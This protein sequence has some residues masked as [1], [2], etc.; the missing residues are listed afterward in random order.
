[1]RRIGAGM[2]KCTSAIAVIVRSARSCIHVAE[3]L[4]A[5]DHAGRV[6]VEVGHRGVDVGA[7]EDPL[8]GGVHQ[9]GQPLQLGPAPGVG[10]VEVDLGAEE[11]AAGQRV[12]LPPDALACSAPCGSSSS[13][14]NSPNAAVAALAA[15]ARARSSVAVAALAGGRRGRGRSRPPRRTDRSSGAP[16]RPPRRTAAP[17]RR[18]PCA[19]RRT[20]SRAG[21]RARW[22]R[23]PD[24]RRW[25]R[26]PP[27]PRSASGRRPRGSRAAGSTAPTCVSG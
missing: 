18:C 13:V 6:G 14:R 15:P 20:A 5:R 11:V 25:P 3:R 19:P 2:S 17:R 22:V 26:R 24:A 27:R 1:M 23:R 4:A 12:D 7:G 10:L 16:A 8:G 21:P 9:V